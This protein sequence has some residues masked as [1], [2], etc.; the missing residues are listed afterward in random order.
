MSAVIV[1]MVSWMDCAL[2][3]FARCMMVRLWVT[4]PTISSSS[5]VSYVFAAP[6]YMFAVSHPDWRRISYASAKFDLKLD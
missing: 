6:W 3:L 2:S 5:V 1:D 4:E